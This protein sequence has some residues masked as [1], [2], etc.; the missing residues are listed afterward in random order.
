VGPFLCVI[1][2]TGRAGVGQS[3]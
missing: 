3:V 1:L 2:L